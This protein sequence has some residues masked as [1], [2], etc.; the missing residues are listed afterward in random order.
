MTKIPLVSVVMS[1]YNSESSIRTA[2]ESI[3]SQSYK[4]IEFLITDDGSTDNSFKIIQEYANIDERIIAFKNKDNIGLTK[5]LNSL[6]RN[7]KGKFIARQDADDKSHKNRIKIQIDYINKKNLDA[8]TTRAEVIGKQRVVPN[9]SYYIPR[10]LLIKYKNP[11]IH[12]S[13]VIKKTVLREVDNYDES[14]YYSQDYKLMTD[15]L[16]SNKKVGIIKR[17]LYMLNMENNISSTYI[18]EQKYYADC[19]RKNIIP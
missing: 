10:K 13:L 1:V 5:S 17:P 19:V 11:Y 2:I 9:F 15:L 12:G 14:F 18:D 3:I 7:S 8:C 4:D 6:I 16:R